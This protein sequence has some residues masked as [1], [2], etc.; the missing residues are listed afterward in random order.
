[1]ADTKQQEFTLEQALQYAQKYCAS[2]ERCSKDVRCKLRE[3]G[4]EEEQAKKI[5]AKLIK[6][7]Y[8]SEQRYAELYVKSKIHQNHW[9]RIKIKNMLTSKHIPKNYI[10]KALQTIDETEYKEILEMLLL[11]KVSNM[12]TKDDYQRKYQL[13]Y[14]LSSHGFEDELIEEAFKKNNI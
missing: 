4:L 9:G 6:T 13:K 5:I 11:R 3:K 8:I 1:M 14:Y 2:L 12:T 10:Q 7:G